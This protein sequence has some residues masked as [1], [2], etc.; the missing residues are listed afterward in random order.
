MGDDTLPSTPPFP[1]DSILGVTP[2]PSWVEGFRPFQWDIILAINEEFKT[3]D[4]VLL[5]AP[6]G[7]GK[8]LIG[9]TTRRLLHTN[10]IYTCTSKALQDQFANDF[11]YAKVVKGRSNYLTDS[12]PLNEFGGKIPASSTRQSAITCADCTWN[13][14]TGG[15]RWC[16]S[17][18]LCPYITTRERAAGSDLAVLNTSYLLTDAN[19]GAKRFTGRGLTILDE[20]DMLEAELLNHTSVELTPSRLREMRMKVPTR[21]TVQQAWVDWV[22]FEALPRALKFQN[23]LPHMSTVS[24]SRMIRKINATTN[25]ISQLYVLSDELPKGNWVFDGEGG[26]VVFRPVYTSKYGRR[27]LWDHTKRQGL[28]DGKALLMS[29]TILS[30]DLTADELGVRSTYGFVDVDSPFPLANR[31]IHVVPVADMSYKMRE[32][33]SWDQI[34]KGV[35]GVLRLHPNDRIL[36]HTVSYALARHIKDGLKLSP[37]SPTEFSNRPIITY[38][39]SDEK[40]YALREYKRQPGAVMIAP[41]MDR[42]VDL[43]GDLCRVQVIAKVP[44]PNTHDKRTNARM[45]AKNGKAWYAAQTVRTIVQM[46]GRGVRSADDHAVTYILDSQFA[47][48]LWSQHQYLF[49]KYWRDAVDWKFNR[50]QLMR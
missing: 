24:D 28:P 8:S 11:P 50:T 30:P 18:P 22:E 20:A 25:L 44:F 42:G 36:V 5:Q 29:A 43:P 35:A 4:V 32:T 13:D 33:G 14:K 12:G 31:P 26:K 37:S 3:H 34:V 46:T 17:R 21:K 15:C 16:S 48:N 39:S 19:L 6:T 9:E 23:T 45:Y 1:H 2:L 27:L 38:N 40:S 7:I 41:S 49:P 10:G 47:S